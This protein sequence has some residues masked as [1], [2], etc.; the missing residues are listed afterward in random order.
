MSLAV[1]PPTSP[2]QPWP[3]PCPSLCPQVLVQATV[4]ARMA[5]EQKTELVCELQRLQ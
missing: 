4:F 5:P 2:A 3:Q 1:H